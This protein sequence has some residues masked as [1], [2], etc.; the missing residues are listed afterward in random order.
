MLLRVLVDFYTE[1]NY[2]GVNYYAASGPY[3]TCFSVTANLETII[4]SVKLGPNVKKCTFFEDN[5]CTKTKGKYDEYSKDE[6]KVT[7]SPVLTLK[8]SKK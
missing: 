6:P 4:R 1:E 8:C 5:N 3:L 2:G 7:L